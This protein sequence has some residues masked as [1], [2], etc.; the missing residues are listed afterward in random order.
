MFELAGIFILLTGA[1]QEEPPLPQAMAVMGDSISEGM[2]SG[3]SLEHPPTNGQ[4]LSIFFLAATTSESRRIEVFRKRYAQPE[5]SWAGGNDVS[6]LVTSH[7]ERLRSVNPHIK[8]YNF[9]VSGDESKHIS[10][11]ADRLLQTEREQN[12][13]MNYVTIL[14]GANDFVREKIENVTSPLVFAANLEATLRKLLVANPRRYIYLVGMPDILKV[15]RESE[16]FEL[17]ILSTYIKCSEVRKKVYG[18]LVIFRIE[19]TELM[20]KLDILIRQYQ[21]SSYSVAERLRTEFPDAKIIAMQS[22]A[23]SQ[24]FKALSVDCFHPSEWGQAEMAEVTWKAGF[25]P[26]IDP[27][28]SRP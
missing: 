19:D 6:D 20:N 17:K 13:N 8:S 26:S 21:D 27:D 4:V 2:F 28:K 23:S 5:H 12:V 16:N 14:I 3:F 1:L 24:P 18:N 25:W 11:Q 22:G 9:A 7:L 15:F 10:A